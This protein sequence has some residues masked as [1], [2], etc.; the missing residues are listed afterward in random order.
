MPQPSARGTPVSVP[1]PDPTVTH[2]HGWR[3]HKRLYCRTASEAAMWPTS[4]GRH[5]DYSVMLSAQRQHTKCQPRIRA[6]ELLS[7]HK[8]RPRLGK[9]P[10]PPA[11]QL[12]FSLDSTLDHLSTRGRSQKPNLKFGLSWQWHGKS[13]NRRH[14]G[15]KRSVRAGLGIAATPGRVTEKAGRNAGAS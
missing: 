12:V 14:H 11:R 9:P 2:K 6:G 8:E 7:I 15:G 4:Q 13:R 5:G 3:A 10:S 1:P